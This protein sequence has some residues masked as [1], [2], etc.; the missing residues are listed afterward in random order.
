MKDRMQKIWRLVADLNENQVRLFDT[1]EY[2]IY[3]NV[4]ESP[5]M[6]M[7]AVGEHEPKKSELI[8][9]L[10]GPGDVF[11]DVGA[12]CGGNT[13]LAATLVGPT[14]RVYAFEANPDNAELLKRS[15]GENG[16][17]NVEVSTDAVSNQDGRTRLSISEKSDQH[18]IVAKSF[19]FVDVQSV[20][21]DSFAAA[22]KLDRLSMMSVDV[23]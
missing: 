4:S 17:E 6:L 15:V 10:L 2:K 3:V 23:E 1:G 14:G 7:R 9:R 5:R 22:R 16:C 12:G 8:R 20:A 19:K 11:V 21:L 18:S 13:L